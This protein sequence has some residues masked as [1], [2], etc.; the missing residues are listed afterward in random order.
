MINYS[1]RMPNPVP[2]FFF[3][4][5]ALSDGSEA[6]IVDKLRQNPPDWVVIISRDLRAYGIRHYGEAPGK[7]ELILRWVLENYQPELSVGGDPLASKQAGG[8]LLKP[9]SAPN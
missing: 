7:G 1:L 4:A 3:F 5:S 9:R 6:A 8:V 2:P